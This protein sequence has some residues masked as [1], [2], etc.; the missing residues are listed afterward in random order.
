[1][2]AQRSPIVILQN[3]ISAIFGY[4]GIFF[5]LRYI[6]E[7]DWGFVAFGIGF[8]GVLS[9]VGDLG[10][11]TAHTIKISEGEDIGTCN[12]TFLSVKL[13]LGLLFVGLVIASLFIWTDVLHKGFENPIEY[14]IILSLIPYFFFQNFTGFMI[15]YFKATLKSMRSSIPPLIE[16]VLRNS[17]FIVIALIIHFSMGSTPDYRAALFLSSTYSFTFTIFFVVSLILGRPWKIKRPTTKMIKSYTLLALPLMLVASVGTVSGNIDKVVIQFFWHA[18]ATGAF[19][20][21]QQVAKVVTTLSTSLSMFFLPLLVRHINL[22][23]KTEMDKHI[24]DFER[25]MSLYLLPFVVPLVVL[26][27]Y[28]MNIFT[29]AY[30]VYS[31]MLALLAMRAYLVAI[32]TPYYSAIASRSRTSTIAKIDTSMV[33]LNIVLILLFV[34]SQWFGISFFSLGWIGAPVAMLVMAIVS[35][36]IYRIVVSKIEGIGYNLSILKHMIPAAIQA[37]FIILVDFFISPKD[38]LILVPLTV[39][40]ILVNLLVAIAIKETSF[41]QLWFILSNFH[42]SKM[43]RL[44]KTEGEETESDLSEL[45]RTKKD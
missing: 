39:S 37:L 11:S 32:N 14:W 19:F 18:Q 42:P 9:L 43:A 10:Y 23:E 4:V 41:N 34:P 17:I 33:L 25:V 29:G 3:V 31:G 16:A 45:A 20:T 5:I 44:F 7:T 12:G 27:P 24:F 21:S 13:F 38:I 30:I 26:A 22:N 35:T 8:V 28:F 36:F 1:M 15:T 2:F 6:G 40:S